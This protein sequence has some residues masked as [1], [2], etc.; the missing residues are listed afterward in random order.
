M[1]GAIKNQI[2]FT[3]IELI[4]VIV[5]LGIISVVAVGRFNA[6]PFI[7]A[8][9]DQ[10]LRAALRYAQK[11]AILSGC[12]VQVDIDA[13][14]DS[15]D[16]TVRNDVGVLPQSGLTASGAFATPLQ[17]PTAGAYSGAA[18]TGVDITAGLTFFYDREGAPSTGG[19][20]VVDGNVITIEPVTG[21]IY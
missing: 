5:L 9:F 3:L 4:S 12:D 14:A 7:S 19:I 18:P 8:G 17:N 11:Y 20:I 1:R 13:A 16:L 15:Y 21:F 6:N 2:G 10:E